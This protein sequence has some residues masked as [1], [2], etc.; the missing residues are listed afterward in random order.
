ML[1]VRKGQKGH[2]DEINV[3][4]RI[5]SRWNSSLIFLF[6]CSILLKEVCCFLG[7]CLEHHRCRQQ[8]TWSKNCSS[9]SSKCLLNRLVSP[10]CVYLYQKIKK[11]ELGFLKVNLSRFS[12]QRVKQLSCVSS[13]VNKYLCRNSTGFL[14]ALTCGPGVGFICLPFTGEQWGV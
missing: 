13:R 2:E 6:S 11:G 9:A 10:W 3:N 12:F 4:W 14:I 8:K 5:K 7:A 1:M